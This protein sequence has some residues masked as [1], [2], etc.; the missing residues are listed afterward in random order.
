MDEETFS[1]GQSLWV[2]ELK[3][4][5]AEVLP[6][7]TPAEMDVYVGLRSNRWGVGLRLEQERLSWPKCLRALREALEVNSEQSSDG[8]ANRQL[9]G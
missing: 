2:T 5:R 8:S 6:H 1:D 9:V 3:P 7:L 4:N